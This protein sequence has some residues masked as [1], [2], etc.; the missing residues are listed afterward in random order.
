MSSQDVSPN[1]ALHGLLRRQLRRHL[2]DPSAAPHEFDGLL[3]AVSEAYVQ[4]EADRAMLERALELTT[5]EVE[6]A[7]SEMRA[8]YGRLV[9][10]SMDGICAF[11]R[12]CRYTV[13][14]PAMERVTGVRQ[15]QA[16]GKL[17]F[18]VLPSLLE[19]G[20]DTFL[21]RALNGE[22]VVAAD[23]LYGPSAPGQRRYHDAYYSPLRGDSGDVI[24][25]LVILRD[26]TE[27]K[28]AE[29]TLRRA[30]D[31]L[32]SRIRERTAQLEAANLELARARDQAESANRT[33][34][35]FLANMS[36]ELRTPLNA[37]IGYAEMLIEDARDEGLP[38]D[39]LERIGRAGKHLL[40]LI[41]DILDL[42]KIEAGK[43]DLYLESFQVQKL[44]GEIATTIRPL[45]LEKS[46]E[47]E[48]REDSE[49]GVMRTDPVKLRQILFNLL[50]N[51]CK[52]T[53]RGTIT[54]RAARSLSAGTDWLVFE[55]SDTGIG[56]SQ[57]QGERIFQPF[58]QADSSVTRKHGG[59]GLGL[60]ITKR[61]CEMMGGTIEVESE[62]GRG[63]SFTVRLP[64]MLD[65]ASE[66]S[67]GGELSTTDAGQQPSEP[68]A[69][70]ARAT[71]VIV[72]DEP[73][74][75]ALLGRIVTRHGL[76]VLTAGSGEEGLR[77]IREVR[78]DIVL[79]DVLM[80]RMDGW[81]V[82]TSLK[83]DPEL[84]EIPVMVVSVTDERDLGYALGAVEYLVKPVSPERLSTL[85]RRHLPEVNGGH[86]LV[87]DDDAAV[88]ERLRRVLEKDGWAV[89]EAENG[90][91]ALDRIGRRTPHLVLLD[92]MMPEMDGFQL[93]DELRN[94]G[95][96]GTF[97]VVIMTSKDLTE[98]DW[99]RLR[100]GVER[101]IQK[102]SGRHDELVLQLHRVLREIRGDGP[103]ADG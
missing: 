16:V 81:S 41:N 27:R 28:E 69:E 56:M 59:T 3:A 91:A 15:T 30:R 87:V 33:K 94:R 74:A 12:D 89:D 95:I 36:H 80:P 43:M 65:D 66:N 4:F 97:P 64:H 48:L 63:T 22:T 96:D 42:S 102:G 84:A 54:L 35:Q 58:T 101:V 55:V 68:A 32:D 82:L 100:G 50:S 60:T 13:W 78:P 18:D 21:H 46:N 73:D 5:A 72:D 53:E 40:G 11:D 37:I 29:E 92:L 6:Q 67:A 8:V 79:L 10:S 45:L 34:S 51:A 44:L 86:L 47:F 14:N 24:G 61:F 71:A 39:D 7:N 23:R 90:W 83:S 70:S 19:S 52:F 1:N 85:L 31:D 17:A 2:S 77:L 20:E 9:N 49:L 98:E 93:L 76:R 62:V 88:R 26:V 38:T 57:E 25:G 99:Q 103:A 75:R